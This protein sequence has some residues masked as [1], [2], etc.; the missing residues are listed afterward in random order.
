MSTSTYIIDSALV[1]LVL[2]QIKERTL[3]AKQLIR[4]L[5]ILGIAVANYLHGIPT[6]GNDLVL[7]G[8]LAVIGGLIG[9]ASGVTVIMRRRADGT[10]SFRSGWV[11]GFFWVL[12]MGSRFAF[13]W[14]A[15][16]GGV[17]SI[18][19]F[20]AAHHI[21]GGDVWTAALLAMAVFE[22]VGRTLVMTLRWKG[23]EA[24]AAIPAR[25]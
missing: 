21:T 25:A 19:S 24:L 6:Q 20:S 17:G 9:T 16:H 15:A 2:L 23:T 4:P 5:I 1:L 3:T 22:V 18:A 10:T 13:A 12:G 7:V 11:S 8:V 14:W